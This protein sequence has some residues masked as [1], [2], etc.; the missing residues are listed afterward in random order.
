MDA[1][2]IDRLVTELVDRGEADWVD[3][4]EAWWVARSTGSASSDEEARELAIE[5]ISQA[6][7]RGLMEV[8]D[9]TEREGFR[10]WALP[11]DQ[12]IERITREWS[13]DRARPELGD[14]GWLRNTKLEE[15][16]VRPLPSIL[17][18]GPQLRDGSSA[19]EE[20]I[21]ERRTGR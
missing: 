17:K 7:H 13:S 18:Q 16:R 3:M 4:T 15:E 21:E 14:T 11:I 5:A 19:V 12:A 9:V 20:L 8:G 2:R 1:A 10:A 6:L